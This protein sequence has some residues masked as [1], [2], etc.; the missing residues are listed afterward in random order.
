MDTKLKNNNVQRIIGRL[1][2][3]L[4]LSVV[5]AGMIASYPIILKNANNII[6]L[7]KNQDEKAKSG[8]KEYYKEEFL[9][10]LYRGNYS[11]YWDMK[12]EVKDTK[13]SPA[14]TFLSEPMI[15]LQHQLDK[16]DIID[17]SSEKVSDKVNFLAGFDNLL[18]NWHEKFFQI[19]LGSYSLEYYI[20]D[21]KTGKTLTNTIDPINLMTEKTEEALK[22]KASYSFYTVFNYN[23]EGE[24]TQQKNYG[25][26]DKDVD[27]FNNYQ[28]TKEL[29]L[30]DLNNNNWVNYL[31]QIGNPSDVTIIYAAKPI[32]F[33]I[34]DGSSHNT[35]SW[36]Q[37]WAFSSGGFEIAYA[38]GIIVV[39]LAA[40]L[41]PF[42][43]SWELEKG[44]LGR[45]PL[46]L[47]LIL[48]ANT[49]AAYDALLSMT[50]ETAV[51]EFI[52]FS[53]Y[54]IL[55][56]WIKL[57]FDYGVNYLIWMLIFLIWF[58]AVLSIR[59]VFSLGIKKFVKERTITGILLIWLKRNLKKLFASLADVDLT[60][61]SNKAIIK[62][63]S[64]NFVILMLLCSIWIAGIAV[65][66]PYSILLFFIMRKYFS[67]I[68][69]KYGILLNAT[70]SMAEGNL[71]VMV[72]ED[73]G[74]FNPLKEELAKVR[75]GF[76]K[77]VEEEMKSQKMK[78][79]LVTNVSHD[80]KT[81]LTAIIT[82]INL[83]KEG[84][85]TEE[86]R[87]SY[88]DT[89]DQK[90]LRLK[91]LI[92][93]LFEISKASSHNVTLNLVDMDLLSLIKQVELE[94]S[95]K[96]EES[97]VEFRHQ[98][99]A[100]KLILTLDS[101]KT[102][103]IFENLILNIT[104]YAM[105][106]TRAYIEIVSSETEVI[107]SI[108]NVSATEINLS[109]EEISERFVRGDK[110]RNTE[111]SGL[112]LAIVKNFVE[113]QGGKFEIQLD[114]DLFK[115]IIVWKRSKGEEI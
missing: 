94:L 107:V 81:P 88:I 75:F 86:E 30:Q 98:F 67:D 111:G 48:T 103:R 50:R 14:E 17:N 79:E 19:D 8:L 54:S 10:E 43:K 65:L 26:D 44:L 52:H 112:G 2:V 72:S 53:E 31:S 23:E 76:K 47:G 1:I 59:S 32:T 37:E 115:A 28:L 45:I 89:L 85:I 109:P 99:T 16:A 90:A 97:K 71:E 41:L 13:T 62:I 70:S 68:K 60:E 35:D 69:Y 66:I 29:F 56:D 55:P 84:N 36:R 78:T 4:I 38:L 25:L 6:A 33:Y 96:I 80:L 74:I 46:E 18:N 9:K 105:P 102:Y 101:D 21:H 34:P 113:L 93:D 108:K 106:H 73:L 3:F 12:E 110:S 87:N 77:A 104:K 11:L 63:L 92:E 57:A 40:L 100:E 24:L 15:E 64:V 61:P 58:A 114:G 5:A 20:I 42:K 27:A 39:I 91:R 7:T 82:Y 51:S 83:L 22:L 95:D 49:L